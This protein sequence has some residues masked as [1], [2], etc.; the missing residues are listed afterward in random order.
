M[1]IVTLFFSRA[2]EFFSKPMDYFRDG[3]KCIDYR[4]WDHRQGVKKVGWRTLFEK[5][6][7]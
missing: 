4:G 7:V 5:I 2:S 6:G 3:T 1:K